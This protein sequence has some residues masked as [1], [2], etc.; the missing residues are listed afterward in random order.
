MLHGGEIYHDRKIE[1]D[2]SV[3]INPLGFPETVRDCLRKEM[4]ALQQ[5]PDQDCALLREALSGFTG[6]PADRILCGNG[7][8]E[9]IMAAV[10]AIRPEK[11][12]ITAPAFSGYRRAAESAGADVIEHFL[13]REEGL[14]LTERFPSGRLCR[15]ISRCSDF[16]IESIRVQ[17]TFSEFS[18][19]PSETVFHRR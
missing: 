15:S 17:I 4:P 14:A 8:S 3:N 9:L 10:R 11:I 18:D 1:Y 13:Q 6:V 5:Y 19:E 16:A 12:L 2:F 7:A